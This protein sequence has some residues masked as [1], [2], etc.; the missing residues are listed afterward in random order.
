[1]V[2]AV[3]VL[4]FTLIPITGW[5]SARRPRPPLTAAP[6]P[7]NIGVVLYASA[8][9]LGTIVALV[10]G[11][12]LTLIAGQLLAMGLLPLGFV[13][14]Q[15]VELSSRRVVFV[16]VLVGCTVI[17]SV[18][19]FAYWG[20]RLQ[21]GVP[22]VRLYLP[23]AISAAGLVL[24]ALLI[25]MA[26]ILGSGSRHRRFAALGAVV[27]SVYLVGTGTRS[28]WA[29][30]ALGI[31]VFFTIEVLVGPRS[32]ALR[33]ALA[34]AVALAVSCAG[35]IVL[36]MRI[37]GETVLPQQAFHEPFWR[38]P[39]GGHVVAEEH[40]ESAE[41]VLPP[42][43]G[44]RRAR[45]TVSDTAVLDDTWLL[46]ASAEARGIGGGNARVNFVFSDS[47]GTSR[48][49][50]S[51]PF[52]ADGEWAAGVE[53]V[54]QVPEEAVLVHI[55]VVRGSAGSDEWRFR[56]IRLE[57]YRTRLP[58]P[59]ARQLIFLNHRL[60]GPLEWAMQG[61]VLKIASFDFRLK[62]TRR[63][64][65]EFSD[66]SPGEQIF[67]H[68]LGARFEFQ[69]RGY[70]SLGQ[71]VLI[72]NPNYIHNFYAFLLFKLG[73]VGTLL[74]L[75]SIATWVGWSVRCLVANRGSH[76]VH[77]AV[78]Y[79]SIWA[80]YLA[81]AAFCPELVDFRVAPVVGLLIGTLGWLEVEGRMDASS[82][83]S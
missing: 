21:L 66:A 2:Q 46:R 80:A 34:V 33:L 70:D 73:V 59:V 72:T 23:N 65:H 40:G 1:V 74:V 5:L 54:H 56:R 14:A 39:R 79:T 8:A 45:A 78:A 13:A 77:F 83:G 60:F 57:R 27:L 7:V 67:G 47:S 31:A 36:A 71:R 58:T 76:R 38:A 42:E 51:L 26:T 30:A 11:N 18:I 50:A 69:A 25:A 16:R 10:R 15:T 49:V 9:A 64:M 81:W 52:E 22:Q 3:L 19:H 62:E 29:V 48:H 6:T 4:G 55:D 28:L 44:V 41:L 43:S 53:L 68:G 75:G 61:G 35:L 63:L 82:P 20:Y 24:V 32:R 17:A 37:P 12:E